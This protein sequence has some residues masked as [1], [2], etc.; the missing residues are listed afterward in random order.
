MNKDPLLPASYEDLSWQCSEKELSKITGTIHDDRCEGCDS[1]FTKET[2]VEGDLGFYC[3]EE[4][5]EESE[6]YPAPEKE[7]FYADG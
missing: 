4:C 2:M 1:P 7:D 3:S 6:Y 5:Q